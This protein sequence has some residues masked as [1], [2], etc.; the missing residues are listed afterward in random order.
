ELAARGSWGSIFRVDVRNDGDND[1]DDRNKKNDGKISLFFLG[2]QTHNSFDNINF[3]NDEQ[4][5]VAEDRGDTLHDQL[6]TLDSVWAFDVKSKNPKPL[7]FIALGRDASASAPG[8]E[9]NEPTGVV[10]DN[11]SP[12]PNQM[13]GT[14]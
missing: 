9:D 6:N 8:Q 13:L 4:V 11:G 5:L 10:V 12:S 1:R 14:D 3:A 7:R 2:D